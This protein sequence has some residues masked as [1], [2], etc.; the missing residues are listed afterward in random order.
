MFGKRRSICRRRTALA[1][2]GAA[3]MAAGN[4][5]AQVYRVDT[6]AGTPAA[7]GD[8]RSP[9]RMRL[10]YP[11]DAVRDGKGVFYIADSDHH[12]VRMWTPEGV[13]STIAGTGVAGYC[14]DGG[15]A[16]LACLNTP[17]SVALDSQGNLYIAEKYGHRVRKVSAA[18]GLISTVAGDGAPGYSGDGGSALQA[19]LNQPSGL[20]FDTEGN[21]YI[22]DLFNH[23]VRQIRRD[24]AIRTFAG[25]GEPGSSGDGGPAASA[26]LHYPTG[27]SADRNGNLF[28]ADY[29]NAR[30]RRVS[31]DGVIHTVAGNGKEGYAGD[32]GPATSASLYLP[33]TVTAG[34]NGE[35]YIGDGGNNR[36]RMVDPRG[37]ITTI[38]GNGEPGFSGDGGP[39]VRARLNWPMTAIPG[40]AGDLYFLDSTNG[41]IRRIDSAGIITTVL[42]GW[43]AGDGGPAA[44]AE[45]GPPGAVLP[46]AGGETYVSAPAL[47]QIRRV[48]RDGTISTAAGNGRFSYT[49]QDG[50]AL[51]SPLYVLGPMAMDRSGNLFIAGGIQILKVAPSGEL[52]V[53]AGGGD[54][55]TI[56]EGALAKSVKLEARGLAV[57]ANGVVYAALGEGDHRIVRIAADGAIRTFAGRKEGGYSGDGQAATQAQFHWISQI[58]FDAAGNLF[59]ADSLNHRIRKIDARGIVS[60]VAGNGEAGYSGDGGP[61][62]AARLNGP[63]G[64]WVDAAGNVFIADTRNHSI[65]KI[66]AQGV[67]TTIAGLGKAEFSGDGGLATHAGFNHPKWLAVDGDGRV[68]VSDTVNERVRVLTPLASNAC[69]FGLTPNRL[70]VNAADSAATIRITASSGDCAWSAVAD[71][72]WIRITSATG[73]TGSG[74]VTISI[75]ANTGKDWRTGRI[76]FGDTS[77]TVTQAGAPQ[78]L[79]PLG[80]TVN[81]ATGRQPVAPGSFATIYAAGLAGADLF[82]DA[83]IAGGTFLPKELGGIR[84]RIGGKDCYV[85]YAGPSQINVL[86]PPDVAPG[87]AEVELSN[88]H[89]LDR[90]WV[91]V[92]PVAPGFFSY[93]VGG[94]MYAAALYANEAVRVD[95]ARPARAGDHLQLYAT[96]LGATAEPYPAGQVLDRPYPAA[97]LSQIQVQFDGR[98]VEVLYAGLVAAG[99]WQINV[100][101]PEGLPSGDLPVLLTVGPHAAPGGVFLPF[102]R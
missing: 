17:Y 81:A 47:N 54:T 48:A 97:E 41:L 37:W 8:G 83:A 2:L 34:R 26:Q 95:A 38:A 23:R 14:G 36:L 96:G 31:P 56:N 43:H 44:G 100:R 89:G 92:A 7:V 50:R 5:N 61:A 11:T 16:V 86:L 9:E 40:A 91:E 77:L 80:A 88:P 94:K 33:W 55:W 73:G 39:A 65:R 25:T 78:P 85:S 62:T 87:I 93:L 67:I 102:T 64:V 51:D 35:I 57:D 24:G 30:I 46:A 76:R 53:V 59:V 27:V 21:L 68:F 19:R 22:A 13:L 90:A 32:D 28:I 18:T 75:A 60:T 52:S 42:G 71:V 82:W 10:R 101:V 72:P 74:S 70:A 15:P 20:T 63:E 12:R 29:M 3:L 58:A 66:N 49:S 69:V 99:L 4:S 79:I 98:K 1:A 45:L 6:F 84:V